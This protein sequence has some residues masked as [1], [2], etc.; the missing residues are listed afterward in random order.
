MQLFPRDPEADET[1]QVEINEYVL[2]RVFFGHKTSPILLIPYAVELESFIR[3]IED[4]EISGLIEASRQLE[5]L[6]ATPALQEILETRRS[7]PNAGLTEKELEAVLRT[8]EH[9][10]PLLRLY[11]HDEG[12]SSLTRLKFLLANAKLR[13]AKEL[14]V[15]QAELEEQVQN[16]WLDALIA[17]RGESR[18]FSC[19]VDAR[20]M[21]QLACINRA[22]RNQ[23]RVVRLI[24]RSPTM[25]RLFRSE[26]EEFWSD[27]DPDMLCHPRAF[28]F[29]LDWLPTLSNGTEAVQTL[30]RL[31]DGLLFLQ[32]SG[33]LVQSEA[34]NAQELEANL[35]AIRHQWNVLANLVLSTETDTHRKSRSRSKNVTHAFAYQI[36]YLVSHDS[37]IREEVHRRV[38]ELGRDLRSG[39]EHLPYD[40]QLSP[41]TVTESFRKR[42]GFDEVH[43]KKPVALSPRSLK[44]VNYRQIQFYSPYI[45]KAAEKNPDAGVETISRFVK[46][47]DA[48][49][50]GEYER[51]LAMAYLLA[52]NGYLRSRGEL[53][54]PRLV[55]ATGV[56][57]RSASRGPLSPG[58]LQANP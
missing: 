36:L 8:I 25:H 43:G 26:R 56:S 45:R 4:E 54:R 46:R 38:Q 39:M 32:K 5:G 27:F 6:K 30:V 53:L 13:G 58:T 28:L 35:R 42:L 37:R 1:Q 40:A 22:L 19:Q 17:V 15:P 31:R 57:E 3:T 29:Q 55:D 33:A 49:R 18:A 44:F 11:L 7:R 16:R 50:G 47:K 34:G 41:D 23:N 24:T 12:R 14:Y 2:D 9:H 52:V 48:A 10:A 21:A 51:R 20:A